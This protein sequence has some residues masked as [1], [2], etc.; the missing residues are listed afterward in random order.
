[1]KELNKKVYEPL[2]KYEEEL[3][4]HL[5]SSDF[6]PKE[7]SLKTKESYKIWLKIL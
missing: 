1:M 2:D 7:L 4:N 3:I 6:N 5:E